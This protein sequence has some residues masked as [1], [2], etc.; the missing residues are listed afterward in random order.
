MTSFSQG[1]GLS[2]VMR[3]YSDY[4]YDIIFSLSGK[5]VKE[6]KYYQVQFT[7]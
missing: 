2:W 5:K 3:I 4:D 6:E 1:K 7:G